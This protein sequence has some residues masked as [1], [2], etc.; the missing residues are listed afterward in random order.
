M[1]EESR[2]CLRIRLSEIMSGEVSCPTQWETARIKLIFKGKGKDPRFLDNYR[3]I[4]VTSCLYKLLMLIIRD[5]LAHWLETN[6][7]LGETQNGFRQG[8]GTADNLFIL[9]QTIEI[10]RRQESGLVLAFLDIS[11]AYDSVNRA[12]LWTYMKNLNVPAPLIKLLKELYSNCKYIYELGVA[13]SEPVKSDRG[14]KQGCPLSPLLFLIYLR[15]LEDML[16]ESGLGI[17]LKDFTQREHG[18]CDMDLPTFKLFGLFYADDIVLFEENLDNLQKL[19]DVVNRYSEETELKFSEEKSNYMVMKG[20]NNKRTLN[21]GNTKV[22]AVE[23]YT[24]LGV[25]ICTSDN[26]LHLQEENLRRKFRRLQ[27]L[28]KKKSMFAYNRPEVCRLLWKGVAV[29]ALTYADE[30][31][32]LSPA[33]RRALELAQKEMGR[34]GL[35]TNQYTADAAIQGELGWSLFETREAHSKI[36]FYGRLTYMDKGR[37]AKKMFEFAKSNGEKTTWFKRMRHLSRKFDPSTEMLRSGNLKG[38]QNWVQTAIKESAHKLWR[39][40][41]EKKSSLRFYAIKTAYR[42]EE[43]H[44]NSLGSQLLFKARSGALETRCLLSKRFKVDRTC[45]RCKREEETLQHL[46]LD[47]P[48]NRKFYVPVCREWPVQARNWEAED[49]LRFCLGFE[50]EGA[51][52]ETAELTKIKGF[53]S[54]WWKTAGQPTLQSV[55]KTTAPIPLPAPP[56]ATPA[57]PEPSSPPFSNAPPF[58]TPF[59]LNQF[60]ATILA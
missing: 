4:A 46:I 22:M 30:I 10:Y 11:K 39:E 19:L 25:I 50:V 44:D 60:P 32:T 33:L 15:R 34:F 36:K 38:F 2:E 5:R 37:L 27:G 17:E 42:Y 35:R 18:Q 1:E 51:T 57:S 16:R 20:E 23:Q 53:L 52:L 21:I 59:T 6:H 8:R 12:L 58:L 54:N 41:V 29:P 9:T 49:K 43:Y 31:L 24:Y 55:L 47:C 56:L 48:K 14:L 3:P 28:V 45:E 7:M 40:E 13:K 26:Y